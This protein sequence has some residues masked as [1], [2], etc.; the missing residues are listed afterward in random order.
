VGRGGS[1]GAGE[2]GGLQGT[3]VGRNKR[4]F[5]KGHTLPSCAT[6]SMLSRTAPT[7]A[8]AIFSLQTTLKLGAAL[9]GK[10]WGGKVGRNNRLRC[11]NRDARD[12]AAQNF[13]QHQRRPSGRFLPSPRPPASW[14]NSSSPHADLFLSSANNRLFRPS[15]DA[16]LCP[17]GE[18]WT[19]RP[20]DQRDGDGM[21][22]NL[23]VWPQCRAAP[24]EK[25]GIVMVLIT[26]RPKRGPRGVPP[27]MQVAPVSHRAPRER[28]QHSDHNIKMNSQAR[29]FPFQTPLGSHP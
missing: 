18:N 29:R 15:P 7:P 4:F 21:R 22:R 2:T 1:Q 20:Q 26:E 3:A 13:L 27:G 28:G 16:G 14:G 17:H 11:S 25:V 24:F 23:H 10:V 12:P 19:G 9:E 6:I 5:T 8:S